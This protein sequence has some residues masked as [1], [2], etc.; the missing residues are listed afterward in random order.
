M[1][2]K[3]LAPQD[4]LRARKRLGISQSALGRLLNVHTLTIWKWE[5]GHLVPNPYH[6]ALLA[7]F[8]VAVKRVPG[9]G[10]T[11]IDALESGGVPAALLCLLKAGA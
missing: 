11:A 9:I 4:V 8:E 5:N 2:P 6:K 1:P 7:S 10:S 3:V